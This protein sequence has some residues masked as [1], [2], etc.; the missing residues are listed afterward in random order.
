MHLI[1]ELKDQDLAKKIIHE[2]SQKGIHTVMDFDPLS[3]MYRLWVAEERYVSEAFNY[4]R[5]RV[6]LPAPPPDVPE[7]WEKMM[8]VPMGALTR[9]LIIFSI[10]ITVLIMARPSAMEALFINQP[11]RPLFES[12]Q[13]GQWWRVITPIFMHFGLLHIFFNLMW[14]KDLGSLFEHEFGA[15]FLFLFTLITGILSNIGQYL[16]QGEKFGGMSGVVYG[17]LALLWIL[18]KLVSQFEFKLPKRDIMLMIVWYVLCLTGLFG[19][20]ANMA[21]GLGVSCGII[22]AILIAIIVYRKTSVH[23]LWQ[24]GIAL[25]VPLL[26]FAIENAPQLFRTFGDS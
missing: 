9:I 24:L 23:M 20:I 3:G 11:D 4:Y 5:V 18:P 15:K 19:P 26:T 22:S 10:F 13:N 6:G 14:L 7:E 16:H 2:L 17:L 12:I 1:G 21:H 8:K 25:L